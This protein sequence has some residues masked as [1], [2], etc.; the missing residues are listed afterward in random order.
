MAKKFKTFSRNP[1]NTAFAYYRYSSDAQ[2]ECSIEQQKDAIAEYAARNGIDVVED[3]KDEAKTGTSLD[4]SGF[5][6]LMYAIKRKRP[7]YLLVWKLDRIS[8]E[9]HDAF[10]VDSKLAEYG[11]QVVS[12]TEPMPEDDGM[13]LM[14]QSIYAA[15]NHNY[16]I[17]LSNNVTRGLRDNAK[18]CLYNGRVILGYRGKASSQYEIDD[19]TAPIVKRIFTEY[20]S[21]KNLQTIANELNAEGIKSSRG[22]D[23][24][25]TSLANIIKNRAYIGEYR[26]GDMVIKGGMPRIISDELFEEAQARLEA[27]ARGGKGAIKKNEPL[28]DIADY[29]LSGKLYCG[30]CGET[31]QGVSGTGKHGELHYYYSCKKHRKKQCSLNN[32]RKGQLEAI[33]NYTIEEMMRDST[34][35]LM[36]AEKCYDY[37]M[38]MNESSVEYLKSKEDSLKIVDKQ[39][40]NLIDIIKDGR[41]YKTLSEELDKLECQKQ[42]IEEAIA[43]ERNRIEHE[44][45]LEDVVKFFDSFSGDVK[46]KR[47]VFEAMVNKIYCYEDKIVLTFWYTDDKRDVS[48]EDMSYLIANRKKINE[49][50]NKVGNICVED[51]TS[52]MTNPISGENFFA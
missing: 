34:L 52:S 29:W 10:Y 21:G 32:K 12:I 41:A 49:L 8:R 16:I 18:K 33:V 46:D 14:M 42:L 15:M 2:R 51:L 13:R 4:R 17:S 11:V 3:F 36:L 43:I 20:T 35:R 50:M 48:I 23:F 22:N 5:Q 25:V 39:I 31:M 40:K 47:K 37:H 24:K 26:W 6:D 27:N 7:A 30:E 38:G 19:V 1:G 45:K 9:I 44:L 28:S